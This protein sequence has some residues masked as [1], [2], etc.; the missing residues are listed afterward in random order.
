M[1]ATG[2]YRAENLDCNVYDRYQIDLQVKETPSSFIFTLI[3]F[4][5][6]Y[7]ALQIED[8]FRNTNK[9]TIRKEKSRHAVRDWGDDSFTLYPYH[10]G[11]P[12][13]FNK[14]VEGQK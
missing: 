4:D 5:S 9:V 8:M 13:L 10:V 2:L 12:Y 6:K 1:L 7:G 3:K 11:V 14:I